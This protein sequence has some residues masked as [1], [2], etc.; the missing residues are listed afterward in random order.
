MFHAK[1]TEYTEFTMECCPDV[2]IQKNIITQIGVAE[3]LQFAMNGKTTSL[4]LKIGR[5]LI[6]MPTI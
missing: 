4:L 2:S 1:T 5:Y 6:D 3:E